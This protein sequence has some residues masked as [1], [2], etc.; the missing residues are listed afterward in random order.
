MA[1]KAKP[2][3]SSK[4]TAWRQERQ[5]KKKDTQYEA[6][7]RL[8]K[9]ETLPVEYTAGGKL[10]KKLSSFG[11]E[12]AAAPPPSAAY[13]P[14]A[15]GIFGGLG[16]SR[17]SFSK[18][19]VKTAGASAAFI[20]ILIGLILFFLQLLGIVIMPGLMLNLIIFGMLGIF[21]AVIVAK[22]GNPFLAILILFVIVGIGYGSWYMQATTTGTYY[23]GK[24]AYFGVQTTEVGRQVGGEVNVFGQIL[25]GTYNPENLWRSDT[26]ESQYQE[27]K[28]VG[29]R[30]LDVTPLRSEFATDQELSIQGRID[31]VSFPKSNVSVNLSACSMTGALADVCPDGGKNEWT[32]CVGSI[33]S[34][35]ETTSQLT[36]S[37]ARN[38]L[39][40][41]KHL[42]LGKT[43]LAYPVEVSALAENTKTVAGKQFVFADPAAIL[44]LP[45]G[46][47]PLDAFGISS[48]S[49]KSWQAGD[50]SINLGLGV[51]GDPDVLETVNAATGGLEY[52]LGINVENPMTHT[53][54]A[55]YVTVELFLPTPPVSITNKSDFKC[56]PPGVNIDLSDLGIEG[57]QTQNLRHCENTVWIKPLTPG[58]RQNLFLGLQISKDQLMGQDFSTFFVL[59]KVTFDYE[60]KNTIP[61]VIKNIIGGITL[62]GESSGGTS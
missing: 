21:C 41:C 62:P 11:K 43:N 20:F 24:L 39:F 59:A 42:A 50:D 44:A 22:K 52:Y 34:V 6:E 49:V 35:G 23:G 36:A 57:I 55:R 33:C 54:T 9:G 32:C 4:F 61:L 7:Q 2:G 16:G 25:Q 28:D 30:L 31:A 51:A 53:G 37:E 27:T 3:L 48:S 15:R 17:S 26:V 56:D 45:S 10:R 18:D 19:K 46:K 58:D 13:Y 47:D 60:N 5:I 14:E 1:D 8:L 12:K 40:S 38:R 29:V